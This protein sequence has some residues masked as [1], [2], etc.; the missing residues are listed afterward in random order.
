MECRSRPTFAILIALEAVAFTITEVVD[1]KKKLESSG[2]FT[3]LWVRTARALS[4]GGYKTRE[5]V[6]AAIAANGLRPYLS[7]RD[8][9]KKAHAEVTNWLHDCPKT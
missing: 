2:P 3:G 4:G 7:I 6:R 5:Q 1:N 9:G 8:Y